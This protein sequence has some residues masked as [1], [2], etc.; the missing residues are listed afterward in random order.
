MATVLSSTV[1][2]DGM[3]VRWSCTLLQSVTHTM[4]FGMV[5][6]YLKAPT[7][8][9][10]S[11]TCSVDL[12]SKLPCLAS[13]KNSDI[14]S[15]TALAVEKLCASAPNVEVTARGSLNEI[16]A[17]HSLDSLSWISSG[18]NATTYSA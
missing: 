6:R 7:L 5:S 1:D 9:G 12:K 13:A 4:T 16:Q 15:A 17:V 11:W 8:L 2:T 3:D 10:I 18:V 14:Y